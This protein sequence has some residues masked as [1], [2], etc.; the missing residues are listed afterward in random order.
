MQSEHHLFEQARPRLL[1]LA[2]RILGSFQ[3]AEDVVQDTFL[4][5]SSI[6]PGTIRNHQSWLTTVCTRRCLDFRKAAEQT[7]LSYTGAWLPEPIKLT[8]DNGES[9]L[10]MASSLTTAFLLM[11]ERLTP[12]E[13]AAFLLH[14]VFEVPY[15]QIASILDM[16]EPTCRKLVSRAKNFVSQDRIRHDTPE[17]LQK[18]F[19][20]AFEQALDDGSTEPLAA[21][22]S[23]DIRL[24][25]DGG[26][27][28]PTIRKDVEGKT[29]VARFISQKAS[30]YWAGYK[31]R[32]IK[33]NGGLGV[34]IEDSKG[35]GVIVTFA[36][37][38]SGR[39]A[40]IQIMRN[41]EKINS[42]KP[43]AMV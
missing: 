7:R 9:N 30:R 3:D 39:A 17:D 29:R 4:K 6:D 38:E 42:L 34:V 8:E 19:L 12:K 28:V 23:E 25:A 43:I 10:E 33:L 37:D 35:P 31:R 32:I 1:G 21:M 2:Y 26:G 36:F 40:Q 27:K 13:R 22:L 14:Q 41:P 16:K 5:W 15:P 18:K 24:S 20:T 11:L